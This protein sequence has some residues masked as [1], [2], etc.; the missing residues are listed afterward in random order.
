[1]IQMFKWGLRFTCKN[2]VMR[3][4][5]HFSQ[6]DLFYLI[7]CFIQF[8]TSRPVCSANGSQVF[9]ATYLFLIW[10][11]QHY[12]F[13]EDLITIKSNHTEQL[14]WKQLQWRSLNDVLDQRQVYLSG[15]CMVTSFPRLHGRPLIG[16]C[17][18]VWRSRTSIEE[19]QDRWGTPIQQLWQ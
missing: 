7:I 19:V 16:L 3:L 4:H 17:Y 5:H 15:G 2:I 14:K 6:L 9:L 8:S 18:A 1:M 13:F 11:F 10:V 12:Y